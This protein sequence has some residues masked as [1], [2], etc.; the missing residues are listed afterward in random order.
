MTEPAPDASDEPDADPTAATVDDP[1][2][3]TLEAPD[4]LATDAK[5]EST[6]SPDIGPDEIG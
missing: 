2:P 1:T 3:E 5:I 6:N 4:A